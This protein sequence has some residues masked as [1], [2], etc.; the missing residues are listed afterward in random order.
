M[1]STTKETT[2]LDNTFEL[3]SRSYEYEG[4]VHMERGHSFEFRQDKEILQKQLE[5]VT[6]RLPAPKV[7]FWSRIFGSKKE[8]GG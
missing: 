3:R 6:L 1:L 2:C 4:F 8:K 5:L 7:G